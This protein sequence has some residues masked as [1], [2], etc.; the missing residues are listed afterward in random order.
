MRLFT[1]LLIS[2]PAFAQL[3]P[4]ITSVFNAA[5]PNADPSISTR[6]CPGALAQIFGSNLPTTTQI[7]VTV[8]GKQ[9]G[10]VQASLNQMIVEIP[11][12]APLGNTSITISSS[13]QYPLTLSLFAP[14]LYTVSG[15]FAQ[16]T[17]T[18]DSSAIGPNNPARPGEIVAFFLTGL[19]QTTPVVPTGTPSP[20]NPVAT[21]ASTVTATIGGEPAQVKSALLVGGQVGVYEVNVLIPSTGLTDGPQ[22]VQFSVTGSGTTATSN[23]A[24]LNFTTQLPPPPL[25]LINNYSGI[26]PGLPNYGIAPGAIFDIYGTGLANT[27]TSLQNPPLK[28]TVQGVSA[29]VTVNATTVN[30]PIY[31]VTPNQ[32]GVILPSNTPAGDGQ[33]TVVNNGT[34]IVSPIHVVP[35]AFG[36]LTLNSVGTGMAA[37]Y[38]ANFLLVGFNNSIR[39]GEPVN[40]FGSGIGPS[41][42]SD[43]NLIA[44]PTNLVATIPVE[45]TVGG[46]VAQ[47]TY[48]GRTIYPGLDQIQVIVPAG[49][50][51]GCFVS[52]VVRTGTIVSNFGT[53][54]I[55]ATGRTCSEPTLDLSAT[56]L[57]GVSLLGS[58]ALGSISLGKQ[59][60]SIPGTATPSLFSDQLSA[61]FNRLTADTFAHLAINQPSIGSCNVFTYTGG[62]A[63]PSSGAYQPATLN[64]GPTLN[65]TGPNGK[66]SVT[67]QNGGYSGDVG[68]AGALV[69][70]A[71]FIPTSGSSSYTF[72]NG[73]G[74]P[75]V[76]AFTA[77]ASFGS[78]TPSWTNQNTITSVNRANPPA[79]TWSGGS[80]GVYTQVLGYS[81]SNNSTGQGAG[82]V[83][84]AASTDGRFTLPNTVMLAM[85]ATVPPYTSN[86]ALELGFYVLPQTFTAPGLDFGLI[87]LYQQYLSELAYQ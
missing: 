70:V 83:C 78:A 4:T 87:K 75:D 71:V 17:N 55:T 57:Q 32:L 2:C 67:F 52:V 59:T 61:N 5:A 86:G 6:L 43:T 19:G 74:G 21:V 38:D 80:A 39:P 48:A 56:A 72:D 20:T 84:T 65:A 47:V 51:P 14:G 9:A 13:G 18:A 45:V 8:A 60:T 41:P 33:I 11:I 64:A 66:A 7:N 26:V 12:D 37:M 27:S 68:G 31:F 44:A 15:G 85:P 24:S 62:P 58:F 3:T 16:A 79:V 73:S 35:S 22:Q 29:S 28:T 36:L 34:T 76:G 82:F 81:T 77:S 49:V 46:Q 10:V 1:A 30:L 40:L 63:G 23:T 53:I 25:T 69:P 42:D 50:N 54:P